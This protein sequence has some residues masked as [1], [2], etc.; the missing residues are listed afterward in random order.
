MPFTYVLL[1]VETESKYGYEPIT[2]DLPKD[3]YKSVELIDYEPMGLNIG[4]DVI[5]PRID[6]NPNH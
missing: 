3:K 2:E 4:E 6:M 1:C 5:E